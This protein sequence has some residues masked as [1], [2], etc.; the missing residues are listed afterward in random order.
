MS[1]QI[2]P[3]VQEDIAFIRQLLGRPGYAAPSATK[4]WKLRPARASSL[5]AA[6]DG[7]VIAWGTHGAGPDL[8]LILAAMNRL[9]RILDY[10]RDLEYD[11]EI[12]GGLMGDT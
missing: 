3:T 4:P 12:A 5:L 8:T 10:V 9:E 6:N 11:A 1:G 2:I 7:R